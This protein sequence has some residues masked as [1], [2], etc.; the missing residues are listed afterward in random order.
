VPKF[1]KTV[2]HATRIPVSRS[3]VQRSGLEAG[4]SI[5]R[6]PNPAATLLVSFS[7]AVTNVACSVLSHVSDI[8]RC[9]RERQ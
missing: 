9:V 3:N 1:G 4:G 5:P 6:R 8:S 7:S 2:S